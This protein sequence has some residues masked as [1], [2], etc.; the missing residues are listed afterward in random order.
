[1][2]MARLADPSR[3]SYSLKGLTMAMEK[4]ITA[5]KASIIEWMHG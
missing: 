3:F 4:Q 1:M 5:A 2:H